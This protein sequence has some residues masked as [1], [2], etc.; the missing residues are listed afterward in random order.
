M[1]KTEAAAAVATDPKD[2]IGTDGEEFCEEMVMETLEVGEEEANRVN[3]TVSHMVLP[4][5]FG[6][7]GEKCC[8]AHRGPRTQWRPKKKE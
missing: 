8:Y 5:T 3:V 1:D 7:W 4:I 6:L 2:A